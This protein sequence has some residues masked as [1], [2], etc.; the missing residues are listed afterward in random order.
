MAGIAAR[1]GDRTYLF[2]FATDVREVRFSKTDTV[3]DIAAKVATGSG[4]NG[5]NTNA[6]KIAE[7]LRENGLTPDRVI[8]LSDMQ[9]W[10]DSSMSGVN[11][12]YARSASERKSMCDTWAKYVSSSKEA[13]ETWLH[14]IHLNGYGDS[15]VDEGGRIN[16]VGAFSEK[17]FNMLLQT[18]GV[19]PTGEDTEAVPTIE[20]IRAQYKI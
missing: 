9:C 4:F 18:E 15:P 10:N 3:L 20:Q 11:S 17:V 5:H 2:E 13:K 1:S 6:W 14:C 12:Y 8:V 7:F 16:Q 19:M